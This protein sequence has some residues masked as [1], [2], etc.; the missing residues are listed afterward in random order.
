MSYQDDLELVF[1]A[2]QRNAAYAAR[3]EI[4]DI[5][6]QI[7]S[8]DPQ[9]LRLEPFGFKVYSQGD[10]DGILGEIFSRLQIEKGVFLEVGV[11]NGLECNSLYL[12]HQGWRGWWIENNNRIDATFIKET[13]K[14]LVDMQRLGL[15]FSGFYAH[16]LPQKFQEFGFCHEYFEKNGGIDLLSINI[17]GN[18]IYL[19]KS[20]KDIDRAYHPKVISIEYN[21]KFPPHLAKK[22]L[23]NPYHSWQGTDYGGASLLALAIE[24]Q[25]L[26]YQLVGVSICGTNAFFVR[27]DLISNQFVAENPADD[28]AY[29]QTVRTLYQP[30]RY[31]LIHDHFASFGYPPDFGDYVDLMTP[32][33]PEEWAVS[34]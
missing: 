1:G 28:R 34:V 32:P 19:L 25:L 13:F 21:A 33:A 20:L 16:K 8:D 15:D 5:I 12:L 22:M 10:E 11:G 27:R 4:Q 3:R 2:I 29:V 24:A 23:Y 9:K 26:N 31:Y 30:P 17:D 18:D 7:Q 14:S 6:A